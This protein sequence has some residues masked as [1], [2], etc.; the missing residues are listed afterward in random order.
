M[1]HQTATDAYILGVALEKAEKLHGA[2]EKL[3]QARGYRSVIGVFQQVA[4]L[5]PD[6]FVLAVRRPSLRFYIEIKTK[7][8]FV[9][10]ELHWPSKY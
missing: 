3:A 1:L 5:T 7:V 4:Q 10:F 9:A 2:N 8:P 6:Q